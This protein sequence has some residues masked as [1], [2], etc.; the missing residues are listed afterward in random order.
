MT[1]D[2]LA[3]ILRIIIAQNQGEAIIFRVDV[4][5]DLLDC[6]IDE[7]YDDIE[8]DR[9]RVKLMSG[10]RTMWRMSTYDLLRYL[11]YRSPDESGAGPRGESV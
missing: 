1:D 11:Q 2:T 9:V 7:I 8:H 10:P 3:K 6:P 4:V 5:A